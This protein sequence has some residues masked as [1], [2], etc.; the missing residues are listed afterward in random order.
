MDLGKMVEEAVKNAKDMPR[1]NVLIAGRSG[2]GKSTLINAVFSDSLATTGQGKPVTQNTRAY[3]K[4]GVP[5]TIFDTRGLEMKEFEQTLRELVDYVRQRAKSNDPSEHIHVVWVCIAEDGRRVEDAEILLHD[6]LANHAP[7]LGVITKA[8][9]D[10]GFRADVQT[11]LPEAAQVVRVRAIREE[12]DDDHI[13]EPMGLDTLVEATLELVPE[14]H[15]RAFVAAQQASLKLKAKEA[16]KV[17]MGAAAIASVVGASPIPFSDAVL[18]VPVQVGMLAGISAV[19][20]L[21]VT[22]GFLSTLVTAA[23]GGAGL[24]LAGRALVTNILK[25]LPGIGTLAGGAIAATTAGALTVALG[26]AYIAALLVVLQRTSG[27]LPDPDELARELKSQI[28][29]RS[30]N[31]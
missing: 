28:T 27:T 17:V 15:K 12:L 6:Q 29:L 22:A 20:G 18:L 11:L 19:F 2:V 10:K 26:E 13:L 25:F 3:E 4:E 31:S 16:Q 9:M 30:N 21:N 7:V 24:T 8:R 1:V 5:I 14:A 23:A